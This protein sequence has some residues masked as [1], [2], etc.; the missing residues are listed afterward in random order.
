MSACQ[1]ADAETVEGLPCT[2]SELRQFAI[3]HLTQSTAV[4]YGNKFVLT[5]FPKKYKCQPQGA[6]E[7]MSTRHYI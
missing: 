7:K 5:Y 4:A 2:P 3:H 6:I 1:Q